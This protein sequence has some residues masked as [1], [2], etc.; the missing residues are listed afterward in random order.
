MAVSFG[1]RGKA[2]GE[3]YTVGVNCNILPNLRGKYMYVSFLYIFM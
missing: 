3:G 1:Q 2:I